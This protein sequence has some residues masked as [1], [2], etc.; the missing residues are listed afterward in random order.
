MVHTDGGIGFNDPSGA[1]MMTGTWINPKT[2]HKFTVRDCFFQDGQFM[3]TTTD[4]Q[5]LDYNTIQN[6][7]QATDKAGNPDE[8]ATVSESKS[9]GN[10]YKNTPSDIPSSL[11]SE[12]A[13]ET[14]PEISSAAGSLFTEALNDN[15]YPTRPQPTQLAPDFDLVMIERALGK[16]PLPVLNASL[17]WP[18]AP[19]KQLEI[20]TETLGVEPQKI[21]E[22][23]I[24]KIDMNSVRQ[25]CIELLTEALNNLQKTED[26]PQ[27]QPEE[28]AGDDGT[29]RSDTPKKSKS[30]EG[31]GTGRS[32]K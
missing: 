12:L 26:T 29:N 8:L 25:R 2:G 10:L 21:S 11:A 22:W 7:I 24:S 19:T 28:I 4:G 1:P 31:G 23:Y 15:I 16:K 3:I 13:D 27:V 18:E 20:L 32:K 14:S 17:D 9:L 30:T 6:Y 5:M